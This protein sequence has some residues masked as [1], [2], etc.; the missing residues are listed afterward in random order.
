M[1]TSALRRLVVATTTEQGVP[2]LVDDPV[3]LE[4]LAVLLDP[5]PAQRRPP[6]AARRAA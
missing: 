2:E 3:A 4:R 1:K 5:T 6:L